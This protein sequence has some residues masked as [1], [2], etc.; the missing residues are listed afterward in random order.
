MTQNNNGYLTVPT[1]GDD[2]SDYAVNYLTSGDS[3][4]TLSKYKYYNHVFYILK[5][6][7]L[8]L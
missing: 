4:N 3:G 1:V 2:G 5:N 6:A 8:N 7:A